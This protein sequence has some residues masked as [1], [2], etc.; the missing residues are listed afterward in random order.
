MSSPDFNNY[1]PG[2]Y[3]LVV[4]G[5]TITGFAGGSMIKVARKTPLFSDKAGGQGD[6]VRIRSRDKRGTYTFT[7]LATSKSNDYLSSLVLADEENEGGKGSVGPCG[8]IDLNGT[9]ACESANGW[10][11]GYCEVEVV[12]GDVPG[13]QWTVCG[14]D[15][16]MIAGGSNV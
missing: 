8:L 14:A 2:R 10:V 6:V 11:V 7:L 16:R 5:V 1:D 9:T 12:D 13:R 4:L 15:L 3:T